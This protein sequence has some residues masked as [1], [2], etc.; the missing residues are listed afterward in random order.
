MATTG[1]PKTVPPL[2]DGTVAGDEQAAALV[3][4]GDEL[5]EE[6][7]RPGAQGQ[8]AELIDDEEPGL[9]N[10]HRALLE[11]AHE[12]PLGQDWR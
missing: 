1:S 5:E 12:M 9:P 7:A 3:A 10:M 2:P 8:V 11:L 6:M 4:P